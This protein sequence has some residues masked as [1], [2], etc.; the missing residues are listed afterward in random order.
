VQQRRQRPPRGP[1]APLAHGPDAAQRLH[2]LHVAL[3]VE[4]EGIVETVGALEQLG[5]LRVEL[6]DQEGLVRAVLSL[7]A[8]DARPDAVPRLAVAVALAH[9]HHHGG[10]RVAGTQEQRRLGLAEAGQVPEVA[11]LA[12]VEVRVVAAD[13]LGRGEEQG[14][15]AI[16]Q[17]QHEAAAALGELVLGKL[18]LHRRDLREPRATIRTHHR[19]P[20]PAS[21]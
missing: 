20:G 3:G 8:V 18:R 12:V 9:E 1:L 10:R 7:R 4:A 14:G 21:T 15:R 6:L 17:L 5:E 16:A 2:H 11:V 19:T 13:R